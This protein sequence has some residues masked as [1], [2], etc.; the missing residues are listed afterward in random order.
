MF[1]FLE[2]EPESFGLDISDL[3]L[4]VARLK[5]KSKGFKL[6]SWGEIDIKK[7]II[8]QG[9]IK[10][11]DALVKEIKK[12]IEKAKGEKIV[13]K[14]VVASLP[15]KKAFLQVI[16]MPKMDE[17]D[18]KTAV[19]F[20]AENH[21]P[22][23]IENSYID[24][25]IINQEASGVF[26]ILVAAVLR[27]ISDSYFSVLK[28]AG[29]NPY[30]LEVESQSIVRA[31]VKDELSSKPILIIDFG[32]STTSFIIFYNQSIIF[33]TSVDIC[34]EDLTQAIADSL[35]VDLREAEKLKIK[36]GYK[37]T[38]IKEGEKV[39]RAMDSVLKDF[40]NQTQKYINY[41]HGHSKKNKLSK[42]L[43]TGRGSN[44]KGLGEFLYYELKIPVE[45]A[46]PWVSIL[47]ESLKEVPEMPFKESIGY[48]TALG[49]ALRR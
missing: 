47:P 6:V 31:L 40:S 26:N 45:I 19:P 10:Y 35:R 48:T 18:L 17:K 23:P 12:V 14:N 33:T 1:N 15:E 27:T 21:I 7:G 41:Y 22:L 29:L 37:K 3:S 30:A 34:S 38:K 24:Y 43:L 4:K 13:I 8:D 25:Q 39:V 9:E 44:L 32:K 5:K 46:S 11:E 20:E 16:K 2:L 49:L 42:I 36:Y 28:K